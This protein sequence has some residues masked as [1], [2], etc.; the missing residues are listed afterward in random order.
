[1]KTVDSIL[2]IDDDEATNF[3]NQ[4]II[5]ECNCFKNIHISFNAQDALD[6]LRSIGKHKRSN[7][8]GLPEIILLD[9]NLPGMDGW[10]F[11]DRYGNLNL[12]GLSN[13]I[14]ALLTI[15]PKEN[16][17][18]KIKEYD[19][20]KDYLEKPLTPE[21]LYQIVGIATRHYSSKR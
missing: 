7:D 6:F 13:T 21:K 12:C 15:A 2:L 5:K 14:V 1:M 16:N 11:L 17:L 4:V 10:E 20:L 19:F 18:Y 3:L 8:V 9:I